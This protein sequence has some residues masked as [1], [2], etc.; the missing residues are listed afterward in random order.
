MT[1]KIPFPV[2]PI[3]YFRVINRQELKDNY[4]QDNRGLSLDFEYREDF[5]EKVIA[6]RQA[7]ISKRLERGYYNRELQLLGLV[8]QSAL[9]QKDKNNTKLR[10]SHIKNFREFNVAL[11]GEPSETLLQTIL[12]RLAKRL[13]SETE[14]YWEYVVNNVNVNQSL[15]DDSIWPNKALFDMVR[16]QALPYLQVL[17]STPRTAKLFDYMEAAMGK[18][19]L[20]EAGWSLHQSASTDGAR[21]LHSSRQVFVGREYS[22][23]DVLSYKR[24]AAHELLGHALRGRPFN[25]LEHEGVALVFEQVVEDLFKPRRMYRYLA[26]SLGYGADGIPR[27]FHEVYEVIWR[28]MLVAGRYNQKQAKKHAFD[29]TLRVFRGGLPEQ[30]GAVFLKDMIYFDSNIKTWRQFN[31]D[32]SSSTIIAVLSGKKQGF[33]L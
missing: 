28:C 25:E 33:S 17:D 24:I 18:L 9:M 20:L 6:K 23:R 16:A 22:P 14:E 13:D 15:A 27:D 5:N 3:S 31:A 26:A 30:K 32:A 7:Y 29:E 21:V 8:R 4:I 11:Y 1:E 2:A 12:S 10:G 19:G